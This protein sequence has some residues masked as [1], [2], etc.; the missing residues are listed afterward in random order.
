MVKDE[1]RQSWLSFIENNQVDEKAIRKTI[2]ASWQR[3]MQQGVNP[4]Q[5]KV[6]KVCTAD[7]FQQYLE[8]N[9]FLIRISLPV[10]E[11]LY[12]FVVG[13][14]FTVTLA[15]RQGIILKVI[16]DDDIR[17]RVKLG[18]FTEG[19]DWSE[20]SAGTNAI[21]TC[22]ATNKPIQIFAH[23][24]FCRCSQ[25]SACSS[26]PIYDPDGNIIGVLD[27]TGED[28]KVHS[29]TLGMV[30]AATHAISNSMAIIR[31]EQSCQLSN[32]YQSTIIDSI[33]E[34]LL[35]TD[36]QGRITHLNALTRIILGLQ[37]GELV[38]ESIYTVLPED[39]E[40]L[41]AMLKTGRYV[42]DEEIAISTSKG[43]KKFTITSRPIRTSA[44]TIDGMVL[45]INELKRAQKIAQRMAGASAVMTFDN[46]IGRDKFFLDS[47]ET[48][49]LAATGD[50]NILLLG[51]S[52]TG[53]DVFAQA[54]H[55]QS[56]RKNGPFVAINCGAIPRELIG[57][58]LFGYVEGAF[59]GAKR[60]GNPGKFELADGGTIFLDEIGEMPLELQ[61][62]LLR[63][64]EQKQ[65]IR[66]GGQEVIPV[67]V[68]IIAATNQALQTR[69]QKGLFRQDLFYRLNVMSIKMIPLRQRVDDIPLLVNYFYQRLTK[70]LGKKVFPI[71]KEYITLLY[72]HQWSGNIRELQNVVERGVN[73]S[74]TGLLDVSFFPDEIRD[75]EQHQQGQSNA[76]LEEFEREMIYSLMQDHHGNISKVSDQLGIARS[77]LYRKL[78]KFGITK[79]ISM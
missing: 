7:V 75:H 5:K 52:G 10:M 45:I 40:A 77:T 68:R 55:N 14:G 22:L 20:T 74:R 23:E 33:S 31:A 62:T 36:S 49:K 63:V 18:N 67:D 16:G 42:T 4:Y 76:N 19:S 2:L 28:H 73:L 54:I 12:E 79:E 25:H 30:V 47:I 72:N 39:N 13:S 26:A 43:K 48:A 60:G 6:N 59:T 3:C 29:H 41:F 61:A 56:Y 37:M 58:E 11:N 57:S 78:S 46:L 34:A 8:E 38:G 17:Q 35:A 70:K 51:E 44:D 65:I 21:G 53:K 71:P 9:E 50:S 24:H 64:I 27:M 1:L 66:I 32:R 15:N 69:V